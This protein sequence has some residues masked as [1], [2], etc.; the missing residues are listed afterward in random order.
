[1]VI[2]TQPAGGNREQSARWKKKLSNV[3]IAGFLLL[4][5]ILILF[6]LA[7]PEIITRKHITELRTKGASVVTVFEVPGWMENV[8]GNQ[9]QFRVH[10]KVLGVDFSSYSATDQDLRAISNWASLEFVELPG[11][12]VSEQAVSNLLMRCPK[13]K[14]MQIVSCPKIKPEFIQI[15]RKKYPSLELGYRGVAYLGIAG[16]AHP[17]GCEIYFLDPG[18]PADKAGVKTGDIIAKFESQSISS[19]EQLVEVISEHVPGDE[20]TL[21]IIREKKEFTLPCTL[22]DWSDRLR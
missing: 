20:V 15:L 11:A 4:S 8:T 18:K 2:P 16:K 14:Q 21:K 6:S 10:K 22:T 19:F 3:A 9:F 17:Q 12:M 13:L 5:V 1:M 7:I